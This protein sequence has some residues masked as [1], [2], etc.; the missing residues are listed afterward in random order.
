[1]GVVTA[2]ILLTRPT[3]VNETAQA[4]VDIPF[5]ALV[6]A[7]AALLAGDRRRWRPALAVLALAGLLRPEG[8]AL[9]LLA[10]AA[11]CS[12]LTG[13][14]RAL[15]AGLVL[16]GPVLW[17]LGDLAVTGDPLWSLHGTRELAETLQRPRGLG[18]ALRFAPTSLRQL[19]GPVVGFG[20]LAGL[21]VALWERYDRAAAP[22][23]V[24]GLGL[25]GF[26][27]LGVAGLPVL[28]RYLLVPA[29]GLALFCAAGV[30]GWAE[31]ERRGEWLAGA[32]VLAIA[33]LASLPATVRDLRDQRGFLAT[34][35][36]VQAQLRADVGDPRV[37]AA[38]DRCG[39]VAVPEYQPVPLVAYWLARS[40]ARVAVGRTRGAVAID[41][42]TP[43]VGRIL[44]LTPRAPA[45]PLDSGGPVLRRS[46]SW[47]VRTC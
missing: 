14:E 11:L 41:Y 13:R 45:P 5:L 28:A 18:N 25:L 22:A 33:L 16:T 19:V 31:G 7:A 35:R 8:W 10:A 12:G 1:V 26:L 29:V 20:G 39:A 47:V 46:A 6:L 15:A 21:L 9:S 37:A 30:A 2:A 34:R 32:A 4:V 23:A 36:A 17:M 43:R 40:P 42:A 27:G 24:V 44:S 3:L 38:V